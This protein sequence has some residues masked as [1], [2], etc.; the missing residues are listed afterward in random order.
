MSPTTNSSNFSLEE[1][2][3]K[4][5][6]AVLSKRP[7]LAEILRKFGNK[8][9]YEYAKDYI[10]VYLNPPIKKRQDEFINTF[11]EE[12]AKR[13]GD[14]VADSAAK[15][16]S[17]Y[18][19]VSTADH[20]GP[21]CHP[22]FLNSNLLASAPYFEVEDPLLENVIV[23]ACANVSLNNSSFPRGL[24]FNSYANGKINTHRLSFLPSNSHSSTV[25]NF[26]PYTGEEIKKMKTIL[27]DKVNAKDVHPEE[28]D[29]INALL[30]EIYDQPDILNC[31]SFSDQI[32]KT[33]F[34][35][36]QKFFAPSHVE[37]PN[38]IYLEQE[39]LVVQL[40]LK[41]H[42]DQDTVINH[43]FF[44]PDYDILTNK[45]FD[46][47]FGA[48]SLQ[49]KWGTYFFWGVSKDKNY[50]VPLW[51]QGDKL[52]SD[53]GSF[54]LELTPKNIRK[55]LE[56]KQILPSM[57]L[58]FTVLCFYY[59]LKC[60]GGFNQVNYLTFMK[61]SYIKMQVDRGNYR[62]IEVCARA[63]TKE[64]GGDMAIAYLGGPNGQLVLATGLDLILYGE[65]RTWSDLVDESKQITL[66]EALGPMMPEL[67]TI[68]YP[69]HQRDP[70]L[71]GVTT[72]EISRLIKLDKKIK[73]CANINCH[74]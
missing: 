7:V 55:A 22:F 72:E 33:N 2:Y 40:I 58:I 27:R 52:V 3:E 32:T 51:K 31:E 36:W 56:E 14:T 6:E 41:Y 17:S 42:L 11:K 67:Y 8:N 71:L 73:A 44:D 26:R 23:L 34:T 62:S 18:Y 19:Y 65:E 69:E 53:D 49:D 63:Q 28:A 37:P 57:Q 50:R 38:L 74:A 24:L 47:V 15:Q 48:F 10:S 21:I 20:H 25:Y 5:K 43:M 54:T 16:L 70:A 30:D 12:V 45:Y 29:K 68:V 60:L 59:G 61:N 46:N 66:S 13:L 1:K 9:L 35:L 39:G 4:I 64:L